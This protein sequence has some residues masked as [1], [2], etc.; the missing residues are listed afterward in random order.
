M[1]AEFAIHKKAK[2][3]KGKEK[4]LPLVKRAL[5]NESNNNDRR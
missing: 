4:N 3:E 2:R 1:H 5:A